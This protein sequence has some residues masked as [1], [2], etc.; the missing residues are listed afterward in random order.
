ML[1]CISA[2]V[3]IMSNPPVI[4]FIWTNIN[5]YGGVRTF[6]FYCLK[7]LPKMGY[8]PIIID[9]GNEQASLDEEAK[10]WG[11][12]IIRIKHSRLERESGYWHRVHT[13][14]NKLNPALLV[15]GESR[16]AEDVLRGVPDNVPAI[17]LCLVERSDEKY[18]QHAAALAPRMAATI[19][20]SPSILK[21]L[22]EVVNPRWHS[23][24]Q[25]LMIGVDI[26]PSTGVR[27]LH[28]PIR[29]IFMARLNRK[30]KRAH[31][32]LPF[33]RQLAVAGIDYQLTV[34]GEGEEAS[35]LREALDGEI[36]RGAVV[37]T[38]PLPMHQAMSVLD[39]QDVL[40]MFSEYEGLPLVLL[41][42][43]VRGVIPV[44]ST[45]AGGME[46]AVVHEL[47]GYMFPVG[48][49]ET[50]AQWVRRL[51]EDPGLYARMSRAAFEKGRDFSLDCTF[52]DLG[53]ILS[54]VI[55]EGSGMNRTAGERM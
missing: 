1:L 16:L 21:R 47:N 42:A 19:G 17:N 12:A 35:A 29:I 25:H 40:V 23:R 32:L 14:L 45:A 6:L 54:A 44:V 13:E 50:A 11:D 22:K 3:L 27:T 41:E 53:K 18:Y 36:N 34:V 30:P 48:E 7:R 9:V 28:K 37:M 4:V 51:A 24:I 49:P 52:A 8:K 2:P 43:L 39:E 20:N 10:S 38:G 46:N 26:P 31:D 5:R 55:P 33:A 15:F